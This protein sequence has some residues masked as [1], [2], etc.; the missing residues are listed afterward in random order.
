M[1]T[2]LAF[3]AVVSLASLFL[4]YVELHTDDTGVECAFLC[5][6]VFSL[7]FWRPRRPAALAALSLVIPAADLLHSPAPPLASLAPVAAFVCA[8]SLAA[9]FSG[10][11]L[12]RAIHA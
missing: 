2:R 3:A 7:A 10:S 8:V 1:P 9:A 12:R 4:A 5:A 6:I 11:Y